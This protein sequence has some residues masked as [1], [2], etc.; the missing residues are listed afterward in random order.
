MCVCVGGGEWY[1]DKETGKIKDVMGKEKIQ[2]RN[3]KKRTL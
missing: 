2:C 3:K 1:L